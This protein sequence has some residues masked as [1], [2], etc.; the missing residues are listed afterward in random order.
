MMKAVGAFETPGKTYP[1]TGAA[2]QKTC[3][4]NAKTGFSTVLFLVG[5]ATTLPLQK[6][7][8]FYRILSLFRLLCR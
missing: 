3:F 7:I 2:T 4:L 8:F 6:P 5:K 1:T